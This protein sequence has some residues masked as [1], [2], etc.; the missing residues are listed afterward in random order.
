[1]PLIDPYDILDSLPEQDFDNITAIAAAICDVPIS[2]ITVLD[3]ERQWFK[4]HFGVDLKETPLEHSF[5]AHAVKSP[6]SPFIINNATEDDR[7][8][9]NPLVTGAKQI[10]FYT[11]IPLIST[12][13]NPFGTLCVIDHKPRPDLSEKEILGLK[14]LAKQVV[15]L[16]EVRRRNRVLDLAYSEL[17][18]KNESLKKFTK[19]AVHDIK[20][21]LNNITTLVSLIK[22]SIGNQATGELNDMLD[23]ISN[24]ADGLRK[25]VQ[26]LQ[27]SA[28][29]KFGQY[30]G[31][32]LVYFDELVDEVI[33]TTGIL[34][35]KPLIHKNYP[36]SWNFRVNRQ[37]LAQVLLNLVTNS[38]KYNDKDTLEITFQG[39]HDEHGYHIYV[40]DNGPGIKQN[41]VERLFH[42]FENLDRTDRYGHKGTGMGLS[43]VANLLIAYRGRIYV[44]KSYTSGARFGIF[45]P[46]D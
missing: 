34:A 39:F 18:L 8:K 31:K 28:D 16:L 35:S 43:M 11:G 27:E 21:P 40:S 26:G 32:E 38:H 42:P 41:E 24:S 44:D 25:Y 7:F 37:M 1:M 2:L 20:S 6:D 5:C 3:Q 36:S 15:Y 45:L 33:Q 30:A 22:L 9:N 12:D 46:Y 23:M 17:N 29:L 13:G 4:S 14:A 19:A 10:I